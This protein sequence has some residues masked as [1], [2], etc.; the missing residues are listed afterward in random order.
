MVQCG[1]GAYLSRN[2]MGRRESANGEGGVLGQGVVV[3]VGLRAHLGRRK[4]ASDEGGA[5]LAQ[6]VMVQD[7]HDVNVCAAAAAVACHFSSARLAM[8]CV[9]CAPLSGPVR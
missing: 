4:G 3:Q 7:G 2:R 5:E 9:G 6:G 1:L 8:R